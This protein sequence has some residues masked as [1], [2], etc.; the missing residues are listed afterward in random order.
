MSDNAPVMTKTSFVPPARARAIEQ[1][2]EQWLE[3]Q[4]SQQQERCDPESQ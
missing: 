4:R 1:A 3:E 2:A